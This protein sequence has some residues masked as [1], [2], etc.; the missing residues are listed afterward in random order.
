[1]RLPLFLAT[2]LFLV[3]VGTQIRAQNSVR[4]DVNADGTVNFS[5]VIHALRFVLLG[6]PSVN[7]LDAVDVDDNGVFDISDSIKF[8]VFEFLGAA[9]P[10]A[11]C[12]LYRPT[13]GLSS[14]LGS[15]NSEWSYQF[16]LETRN[17]LLRGNACCPAN[18]TEKTR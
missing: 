1:M 16:G 5:D 15:Y 18:G 6:T 11:K 12:C 13:H 10:H 8:L 9:P 2:F 7:C 3:R 4:P 17:H 14:H